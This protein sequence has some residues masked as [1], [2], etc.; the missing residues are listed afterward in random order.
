MDQGRGES[1]SVVGASRPLRWVRLWYVAAL[2]GIVATVGASHWQIERFLHELGDDARVINIAGRQRMLS[3]KLG[4]D[5]LQAA[6]AIEI[7]DAEVVESELAQIRGELAELQEVHLALTLGDA[8]LGVR[9]SDD[10]VVR[11]MLAVVGE[12]LDRLIASVEAFL[13]WAEAPSGAAPVDGVLASTAAFLP[14][15]N[16]AVNGLERE[17]QRALGGVALVDKLLFFGTI[18]LLGLEVL[19]IFEPLVRRLRRQYAEL[20]RAEARA[21]EGGLAKERFLTTMSHELR[22]PL[23]AVIGGIDSLRMD[24]L[25]AAGRAEREMLV[26]RNARHLLGLI[27]DILDFAKLEQGEMVIERRVTKLHQLGAEIISM[28][29]STPRSPAV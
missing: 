14:N 23:T 12:D 21:V 13:L 16:A 25:D 17:S 22:T 8:E 1:G 4:R 19:I 26:A 9:P 11:E 15:M 24:E 3:Q 6:R 5:V 2:L 18:L 27:N 28:T 10:P 20:V 7:R 29:A